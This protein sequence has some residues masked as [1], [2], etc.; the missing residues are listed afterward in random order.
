MRFPFIDSEQMTESEVR[1]NDKDKQLY[2]GKLQAATAYCGE[3]T[4]KVNRKIPHLVR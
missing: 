2:Q 1:Q 4:L 3:Q